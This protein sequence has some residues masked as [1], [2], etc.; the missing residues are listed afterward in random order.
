MLTVHSSFCGPDPRATVR[1]GIVDDD[2]CITFVSP[3]VL[4][5]KECRAYVWAMYH[6]NHCNDCA[7][8]ATALHEG[9]PDE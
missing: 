3:N 1:S 7:S 6:V 8:Y 4:H 9:D 2:Q 5:S